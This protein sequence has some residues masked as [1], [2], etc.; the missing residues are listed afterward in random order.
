M[1]IGIVTD[2][3]C[4]L[5]AESARLHGIGIVPLSVRFGDGALVDGVDLDSSE[6]WRRLE[7]SPHL[8]ETA[9]PSPGAFLDAFARA[10][11]VDGIVC[12]CLS[13]QLSATY[14]SAVLAAE[15]SEVPVKVV[16]TGMVSMALG[17]VAIAAAEVA[18]TDATLEE[19]ASVAAQA[20]SRANV[21]AAL[22]TLEYLEKGGRVG[23][24][25]ALLGGLLDI[26]PLITLEKGT[27]AA[28][29]R[30][31]TR[32][33]AIA[34]VADHV[35]SRQIAEIAIVHSSASDVPRLITA[36][37]AVVDD[38]IVAELGPVVG[39]HTGPGV[40]GVAYLEA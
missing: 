18:R 36:L 11:G 2:S 12:L 10:G 6:F 3:S 21:F 39:T 19:V 15:E 37:G 26:K 14:Q 8:P 20:A 34:A 23:R 29:G 31:R 32:S 40:L 5:P 17:L 27:V 4:D 38:P 9:A 13:S 22:D 35:A 33:K 25:S 7:A 1:T 30:V 24:V 16:D 28:G